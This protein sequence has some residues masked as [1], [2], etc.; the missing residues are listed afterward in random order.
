MSVFERTKNQLNNSKLAPLSSGENPGNRGG[1]FPPPHLVARDLRYIS[2]AWEGRP[3]NVRIWYPHN[4]QNPHGKPYP[5]DFCG[6]FGNHGMMI[7][8]TQ[9]WSKLCAFDHHITVTKKADKNQVDMAF[10]ADFGDYGV[11]KS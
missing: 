2:S 1:N 9:F 10:R 3:R 4:R 7:K 5:P 11:S 8:G 6:F